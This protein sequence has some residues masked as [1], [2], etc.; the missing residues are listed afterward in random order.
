MKMKK[1][2]QRRGKELQ[3]RKK[4]KQLK[5][6]LGRFMNFPSIIH[7]TVKISHKT[8]NTRLQRIIAET[9]LDLNGY[10]IP[11]VLS[12]ASDSGT[13]KGEMAFEVGVADGLNFHYIDEETYTD[14]IKPLKTRKSFPV[15]DTLIIVLYHYTKNGKQIPLNFDHHLI[16]FTFKKGELNAY[17]FHMKGIRR[18]PLD[19]LLHQLID[20]IKEKMTK[21]QL[22]TFNIEYF[23]TL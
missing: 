5:S 1:I 2:N 10:T 7:G 6:S 22:K 15:L 20:R 17:I 13:H 19:D 23:R 8:S 18:M 3:I 16:R 9:L 4:R 21:N 12:V 14:L 11:K